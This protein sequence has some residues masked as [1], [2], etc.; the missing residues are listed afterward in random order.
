MRAIM[1]WLVP[2]MA[3]QP[4]DGRADDDDRR[5]AD[6]DADQRQERPQLVREDGLERDARGVGVEGVDRLH[7]KT[8][9]LNFS[10]DKGVPRLGL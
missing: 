8:L 6:D 1:K 3:V 2:R 7:R 4:R 10:G 9:P 5:D